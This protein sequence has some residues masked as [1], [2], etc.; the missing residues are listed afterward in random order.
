MFSRGALRIAGMAEISWFG[1]RHSQLFADEGT[2]HTGSE[3]TQ[4]A[5]CCGQPV[6]TRERMVNRNIA[7][8][9]TTAAAGTGTMPTSMWRNGRHAS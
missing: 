1:R 9:A 4:T 3:T 6:A 8:T 2:L 5:P 7:V